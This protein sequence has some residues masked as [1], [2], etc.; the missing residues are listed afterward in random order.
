MI[1]P[2]LAIKSL[3]SILI[4]LSLLLFASHIKAQSP[5]IVFRN[6]TVNEGLSHNFVRGFLQ[7]SRGFMWI[8]T[9][10]GLNKFDGYTF[11]TYKTKRNDTTSL[12]SNN[13]ANALA[14]DTNGNIWIGTWGG[15]ICIY[16]RKLDTFKRVGQEFPSKFIYSLYKDSKNRIWIG[17]SDGGLILADPNKLTF[18]QFA[19]DPA[20]PSSLSHNGVQSITEDDKGNLWIG[21]LGG[22]LNQFNPDTRQFIHY[23][24]IEA[25]HESPANDVVTSVFYDSKKRLW[26]ST[27]NNTLSVMKNQPGKFSHFTHQPNDPKSI[28]D[29][30]IISIAE[31]NNKI[32]VGTDFGLMLYNEEEN[33]FHHYHSKPFDRKSISSSQIKSVYSDKQGRLWIGSYNGGISLFDKSY[34]KVLHYY[35][36]LGEN[37]LSFNDVSAFEQNDDGS[38]LIGTDGGGLN[39]FDRKTGRFVHYKYDLNNPHGIG[40]NFIKSILKDKTGRIWIGLWASGLNIFDRKKQIFIPFN[41]SKTRIDGTLATANVTCLTQ[42]QDGFIWAGTW[43]DGVYRIDPTKPSF[44]NFVFNE[45]DLNSL[46]NIYSWAIYTD[47]KNNIWVGSSNGVLDLYNRDNKTFTH[48]STTPQGENSAGILV[49]SED[50]KGRIWA[51][52]EGGGLKL[53]DKKTGT[54]KT[55][56]ITSGLPSD[57]VTSIE[58]DHNGYLWIGTNNGIARFDPETGKV[59][60]YGLNYGFQSLQFNRQASIQLKSGEMLFGGV[61]G[62]N[63]FH[64]DSLNEIRRD[65]PIAFTDF[66]IFNKPVPIGKEGSPLVKDINETSEITLP[67]YSSV[68]SLEYAALNFTDQKNTQYKYRLQGFLDEVW[69]EVGTERKVTYTNLEPGTYTFMVKASD[70]DGQWNEKGASLVIHVL[71]PLWKTW[72]FRTVFGVLIVGLAIGYYR[73]RVNSIKQQNKKLESLVAKRTEELVLRDEEIQAQNNH[74]Y[75][76]REELEFQNNE[77]KIARQIIE[78]HNDEIR[79]RNETLEEEVKERTKDLV[80]YNQLLEQFAFISAHNLRAPVARILGLGNILELAKDEPEEESNIVSKLVFVTRELDTV[81][82]DL[83]TILVLRKDNISVITEVNLEEELK[84]IKVNLE[85]EILETDAKIWDDFSRVNYIHTIKPYLYSILINLISNAI[86]YRH[87]ERCPV[88]QIKSEIIENYICLTVH[89]NGL[90]INLDLHKEKL[91]TL[92]GRFHNHVEGKGMGLYLVKTQVVALGGKIEVE[93]EVNYGTIFKIFFKRLVV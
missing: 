10:D 14:E 22:G 38:L 20:N 7:D 85:K 37:S 61:N 92:Y 26:I 50:S 49:I 30:H 46:S 25:D 2:F 58:E 41:D 6:F 83:N 40:G 62:F 5:P 11:K 74:L 77:L 47:S 64:P 18:I 28:G 52:L 8:A 13:I 66:Q 60:N 72:W 54:F 16:N 23:P 93:S 68:F 27:S 9:I 15:G 67:S 59:K 57:Y 39:T 81:V 71:P 75:N 3:E 29:Y 44:E 35:T 79:L 87:P 76:Q 86:K 43:G 36:Y 32:W 4:L 56:N 24:H 63:I 73:L 91:F 55:Y 34:E 19:H 1:K 12:S 48:F 17:T 45:N 78:K 84:L 65:F 89:D 51:G 88:I 70:K 42:D 82:K 33:N 90:G 31:N 69:Q 80:E 21:T 53:L